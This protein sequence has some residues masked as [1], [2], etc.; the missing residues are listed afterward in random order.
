VLAGSDYATEAG[1]EILPKRHRRERTQFLTYCIVGPTM[2]ASSSVMEPQFEELAKHIADDVEKRFS[3]R[4]DD[5]EERLERVIVDRLGDAE[6]GLSKRFDHAEERLERVIVDRLGDAEKGLS[7][8]FDEAEE[9]LSKR[10]DEAEERLS[11]RF[12]EA[13]ERLSKRFD[14]AEQRLSEGA[15]MN[16]EEL[17]STI[18]V[19]AEGYGSTLD[20][21]ERQLTELN[22]KFDTKLGDHDRVLRDHASRISALERR[23]S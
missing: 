7:K 11:K 2:R 8:R 5:A 22:T 18:K 15:R 4:F 10:F 21:I 20:R 14:G 16:M 1:R 12:D 17:R 19:A 13:E 9:G 23:N 3:K 6:K